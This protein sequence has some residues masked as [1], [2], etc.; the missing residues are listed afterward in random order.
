MQF[1]GSEK[2][3]FRKNLSVHAL[4]KRQIITVSLF[5][6]FNAYLPR[7]SEKVLNYPTYFGCQPKQSELSPIKAFLSL[8]LIL[9]FKANYAFIIRSIINKIIRG[10]PIIG[11][12]FYTT[13][14]STGENSHELYF[15]N[16]EKR[17]FVQEKLSVFLKRAI[18]QDS[19]TWSVWWIS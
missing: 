19:K 18:F 10:S 8:I 1:Q 12:S 7:S 9:R 3:I 17:A 4:P 2:I 6:K 14:L 5:T 13:T 11:L 15:L 16:N